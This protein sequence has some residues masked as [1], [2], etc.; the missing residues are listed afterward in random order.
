MKKICLFSTM[1][2]LSIMNVNSQSFLNGSF[3]N[4]TVTACTYNINNTAF[5]SVMSNVIGF[6]LAAELDI[7]KLDCYI[8]SIPD[9]DFVV[10]LNAKALS[11][12]VDAIALELSSPLVSG[13]SYTV[14]FKAQA[15]TEFSTEIATI[16][17]GCSTTSN[18]MIAPTIFTPT[19][20]AA[21]WT[22]FSFNF[23]A[24]N[25]GKYITVVPAKNLAATSAWTTFDDFKISPT[26]ATTEQGTKKMIKI[27]PN[28]VQD[29]ITV[30]GLSGK[31]NYT[32]LNALGQNIG[33]GVVSEN[34][35]IAVKKITKGL[36]F[37]VLDNG[38]KIKFIKE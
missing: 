28:P 30:A 4:T 2:F 23:V 17:I 19:L 26:L 5:N 38:T 31:T 35:K 3:E 13:E 6:G 24:P 15:N 21:Q 11:N 12:N 36:Y 33:N 22:S 27:F 9:G 16:N 10:S 20:V 18:N 1:L 37:L 8:S 29:F 32:I 34:E 7:Q 14:T 25:N